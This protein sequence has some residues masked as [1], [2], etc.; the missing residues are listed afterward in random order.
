MPIS[1]LKEFYSIRAF[2]WFTVVI[3]MLQPL[4]GQDGSV[5]WTYATGGNIVS[6]PALGDE[7]IVIVGANDN[8]VH[9]VQPGDGSVQWTFD[10]EFDVRRPIVVAEDGTIYAANEM[11]VIIALNPDGTERWRFDSGLESPVTA[12]MALAADG[13]L[14]AG[15]G[16]STQATLYA[17]N[18]DGSLFWMFSPNTSVRGIAIGLDGLIV[19][20]DANGRI[21]GIDPFGVLQWD[22]DYSSSINSSPAIGADG[23][24][25]VGYNSTT[26]SFVAVSP[27]DGSLI[28]EAT[29]GRIS[30]SAATGVDGTIY[31]PVAN[32]ADEGSVVALNPVDG[33]QIWQFDV[34]GRVQTTPAVGFDGCIYFGADTGEFYALRPDGTQKWVLEV[35]SAV[36]SS[37]TIAENGTI[38]FGANNRLLYAVRSSS[39]GLAASSWPKIQRDAGNTGRGG[40]DRTRRRLFAPQVYYLDEQSNAEVTVRHIGGSAGNSLG[41]T[42]S[43]RVDVLNRDGSVNFSIEDSVEPGQT[44]TIVLRAPGNAVYQGAAV[45][46]A[47]VKDGSFLAA[48]L[49]WVLDVPVG[50]QPLRIGAFF[51]DPT[52]AAQV[53]HF[54]AE[55]GEDNGLGIAIQNIGENS[56][57]CELDFLNADGTM[58][59][60]T[61]LDLEPN[62]S[63]VDFFNDTVLAGTGTRLQGAGPEFEGSATLFCDAPVVAVAVNQDFA[64]GA[65]PTDRLTVKGPQ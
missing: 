41:T 39:A 14:Y 46:D 57:S 55:A 63:F 29:L 3:F 9:A 40:S 16:G 56:I 51:S 24:I 59:A 13:T 53:H 50:N 42:A 23:T 61:S 54:P 17:V 1:R 5:R 10:T 26:T 31:V 7:G 34:G 27:E 12:D 65:F 35:G 18:P 22:E 21:Y 38:F 52:E 8:L 33:S 20:T 47:A 11:G 28:W 60:E 37:P 32:R 36:R 2:L 6:S 64:N 25:Y 48:F 30:A 58:A 44:K 43:F 19:I 62:G 4:R 15:I 45:I 49:T